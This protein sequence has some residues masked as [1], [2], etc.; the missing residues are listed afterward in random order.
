MKVDD[1]ISLVLEE[2]EPSKLEND[3]EEWDNDPGEVYDTF[4]EFWDSLGI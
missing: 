2:Y 3:M 4:E 1:R